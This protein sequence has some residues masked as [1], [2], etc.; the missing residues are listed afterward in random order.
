M[1]LTRIPSSKKK[2]AEEDAPETPATV[3]RFLRDPQHLFTDNTEE[4]PPAYSLVDPTIHVERNYSSGAAAVATGDLKLVQKKPN[5]LLAA[6]EFALDYPL[7]IHTNNVSSSSLIVEH[8]T[9][10]DNYGI[11]VVQAEVKAQMSDIKDRCSITMSLN[12]QG[13]YDVFVSFKWTLLDTFS[14]KCDFVV[15]VP[16]SV[17]I[18]HPGIRAELSNDHVGMGCLDNVTFG[19]IDVLTSKSNVSLMTVSSKRICIGTSDG[20]IEVTC[21]TAES[22]LEVSTSNAQITLSDLHCNNLNARTSNAKIVLQEITGCN[23]V[24]RTTNAKIKCKGANVN[25]LSI[26]TSNASIETDDIIVNSLRLN[27]NNARIEGVWTIKDLLDVNTSNSKIEG[28]IL[29]KNPQARALILLNTSNSKIAATLPAS[30]FC[31][32]FDIKTSNSRAEVEWASASL[33]EQQPLKY[34]VDSK[35]YKRGTIG[36]RE[37]FRHE[38]VA[39]TSNAPI[40]IRFVDECDLR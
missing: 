22:E 18:I 31:G 14:T 25:D 34:V 38:L 23:I 30:V 11:I 33:S 24:V 17:N 21:V 32:T 15:R 8:D 35:S 39:K 6:K 37:K 29:L 12:D 2:K 20:T 4:L 19:F 9:N 3:A 1:T 13:E 26:A 27:T 7:Y 16:T 10:P 36:A 28:T 5:E 40:E